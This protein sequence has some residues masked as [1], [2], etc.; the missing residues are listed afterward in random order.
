[1]SPYIAYPF[2]F[3]HVSTKDSRLNKPEPLPEHYQKG[4]DYFYRNSFYF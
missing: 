2:M 3:S 1:M 4:C